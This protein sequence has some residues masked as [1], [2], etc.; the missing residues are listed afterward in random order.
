MRRLIW[1]LG[2]LIL[3]GLGLASAQ[4]ASDASSR[5]QGTWTATRA[6]RD[7]QA[8]GD[9]VGN[10]LSFTGRRF[11][12]VSKDGQRLYAGTVRL[13]PGQ[14]PAALD[15]E[16]A[17]GSLKG[18][19]WKGIYALEGDTLKVCDNAP[20]PEKARPTRF[21]ARKGSGHVMVTF[22]RARP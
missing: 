7:G 12:I 16:H 17:D 2:G 3:T 9:I 11:E 18:K 21:E 14:K 22:T 13:D 15:F 4:P 1:V 19:A 20:D 6:E 10:R 8:A 5:L